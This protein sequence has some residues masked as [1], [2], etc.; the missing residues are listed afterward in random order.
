MR[1]VGDVKLRHERE[2]TISQRNV[3]IGGAGVRVD[4]HCAFAYVMLLWL[5]LEVVAKFLPSTD[6]VAVFTFA[7]VQLQQ[8]HRR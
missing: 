6:G 7:S 4:V 3:E 5:C 2:R 8:R 1:G